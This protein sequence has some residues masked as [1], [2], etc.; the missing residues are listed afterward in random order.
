MNES[1]PS[2]DRRTTGLTFVLLAVLLGVVAFAYSSSIAAASDGGDFK[3]ALVEDLDAY[4]ALASEVRSGGIPYVDINAEHLPVALAAMV[5]VGWVSELIGWAY[6]ILWVPAM[7]VCFVV[8][9]TYVARLEPG[10]SLGMRYLVA[11]SP[12]LPLVLFR[13][14][15]LIGLFVA[16]GVAAWLGG[17]TAAGTAW[18][19]VA[20]FGK[21]WPI[22]LLAIPFKRE[23]AHRSLI[24][25]GVLVAGLAAV[26]ALPGFRAAREFEGVH[27]ET[28]IG[29][30]L[31]GVRQIAGSDL[32]LIHS[33]GAVYIEAQV[34]QVALNSAIGIAVIALA[35]AL[36]GRS[37]SDQRV[38][39]LS[40]G[41]LVFGVILASPLFSTQF[42]FWPALFV[43]AADRDTR[44]WY[45]AAGVC[46]LA[47]VT[48]FE[49]DD[50]WW[51]V[52]DIAKNAFV[53][54][55]VMRLARS[56]HQRNNTDTLT[57][58]RAHP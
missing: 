58:S 33:A 1:V 21:G 23:G 16:V 24:A 4:E 57:P 46:G 17:R 22:T 15:P 19:A 11:A 37:G 54:V 8:S 43:A 52:V 35:V 30:L 45:F 18:T 49:P 9:A 5:V 40:V 50:K 2:T 7:I 28:V 27:S 56:I 48:V 32:G 29:S 38:L 13:V 26:V 51:A 6:W 20:T 44:R 10:G 41:L 47:L 55:V 34:W 14:E 25:A 42:L 31:L 3:S 53:A 36:L 39:L 12:L